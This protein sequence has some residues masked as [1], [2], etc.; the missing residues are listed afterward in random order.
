MEVENHDWSLVAKQMESILK[1]AIY[2]E[3][4]TIAK[5]W[6]LTRKKLE[7]TILL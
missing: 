3:T 7:S 4:V 1:K 6:S 5:Y 2:R